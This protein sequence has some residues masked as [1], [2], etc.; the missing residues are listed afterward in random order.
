MEEGGER[1]DEGM[2]SERRG[3]GSRTE[4]RRRKG[5]G[6]QG[7]EVGQKGRGGKGIEGRG[8]R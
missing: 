8:R 1:E 7:E 5:E 4:G 3:G 2:G 6:G